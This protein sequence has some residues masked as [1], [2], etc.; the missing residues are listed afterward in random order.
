MSIRRLMLGFFAVLLVSDPFAVCANPAPQ[1]APNIA[2]TGQLSL[3]KETRSRTFQ[4]VV[5]MD[6][7]PGFHVN[8]AKPLEKFLIATELQLEGPKGVRI[9]RVI[10][11]RAVLRKLKFSKKQ[12]SVYEGRATMR[13]TVAVPAGLGSDIAEVKARLR[14]QS[15][16]DDFCFPPQTRELRMPLK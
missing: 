10:Y 3:S 6:I 9:G 1:S 13:F 14:Y 12:V 4:G 7:P 2:V 16:S 15:C 5:T 11:P 8:S